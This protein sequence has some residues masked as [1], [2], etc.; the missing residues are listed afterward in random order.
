MN[1]ILKSCHP[2]DV[3]HL[4]GKS[5]KIARGLMEICMP[6]IETYQEGADVYQSIP[7][8]KRDLGKHYEV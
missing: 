6:N 4:H 5:E 8:L 3:D 2:V 7:D 1:K